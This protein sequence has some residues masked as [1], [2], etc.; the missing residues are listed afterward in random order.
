MD[1]AEYWRHMSGH[2][3]KQKNNGQWFREKRHSTWPDHMLDCEIMQIAL[4][5]FSR[6]FTME[7]K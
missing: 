7:D 4:A 3:S 1:N 5:N 6:L 2:V